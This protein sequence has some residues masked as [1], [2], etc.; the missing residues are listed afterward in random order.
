MILTISESSSLAGKLAC[1]ERAE[2]LFAGLVVV[3]C[4]GEYIANFKT[5]F[6]HGDKGKKERLEKR[7]TILLTAALALELVCL[8]QTNSISAQ[9]I[10]S[11]ADKA[12]HAESMAK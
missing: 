3:G 9:L 6:T 1:W 8:V 4:A 7:S 12:G 11:L 10:G 2:Y 5:W